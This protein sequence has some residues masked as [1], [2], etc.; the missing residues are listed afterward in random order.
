VEPE[1]PEESS[2]SRH[3]VLFAAVYASGAQ[4]ADGL[5]VLTSASKE[6][7]A[8]PGLLHRDAI[9]RTDLQSAGGPTI[10]RATLIGL[11]V[12]LAAGLGTQ[13]MWVTGLIGATVGAVVGYDDRATEVRE[14]GSLLGDIVPPGG[15]AIVAVTAQDLAAR[16]SQQ[17]DL[18]L[19]TR[20]IPISG[21]RMSE[22]A[23]RL[24]RGNSRVTSALDD[25]DA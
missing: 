19:E 5:R 9:G 25:R 8:G 11:A 4:A 21:R 22:L 15:Y 13:L 1:V 16:L 17:F 10:L 3:F 6:Q 23:R 2:L 20:M 14:L 7:I 24:A 18:A 12:G